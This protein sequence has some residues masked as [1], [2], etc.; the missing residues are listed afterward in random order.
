MDTVSVITNQAKVAVE[1]PSGCMWLTS[2]T[3]K[4]AN[5]AHTMEAT[6]TCENSMRVRDHSTRACNSSVT[7]VEVMDLGRSLSEVASRHRW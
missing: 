5:A 2:A 6:G 3:S 4:T 7:S 1:A